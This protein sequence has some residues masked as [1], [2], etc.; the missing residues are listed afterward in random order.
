MDKYVVKKSKILQSLYVG[1]TSRNQFSIKS[2][3]GSFNFAKVENFTSP[4][5]FKNAQRLSEA[6]GEDAKDI[7]YKHM[8]EDL[9]YQIA[10]NTWI[11][12]FKRI[13]R[14]A[15]ELAEPECPLSV[16]EKREILVAFRDMVSLEHPGT[17]VPTEED[18]AEVEKGTEAIKAKTY[19]NRDF[20]GRQRVQQEINRDS[21][22]RKRPVSNL[23]RDGSGRRVKE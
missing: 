12:V 16:N 19:R 9:K 8:F 11:D 6:S 17:P 23:E 14:Y 21:L 20:Y 5:S 22:G 13:A 4:L 15:D 2:G 18:I 3:I 7:W 10:A 1:E